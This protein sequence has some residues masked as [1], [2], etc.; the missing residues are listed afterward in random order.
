MASSVIQST[1]LWLLAAD[2]FTEFGFSRQQL[3]KFHKGLTKGKK[4]KKRY[5]LPALQRKPLR[6]RPSLEGLR[7]CRVD[8]ELILAYRKNRPVPKLTDADGITRLP[9]REAS[10]Q[11]SF[12]P[13]QLYAMSREGRTCPLLRDSN[14]QEVRLDRHKE[15][16]CHE[17]TDGKIG[18][19]LPYTH[20]W[21]EDQ[22]KEMERGVRAG[23]VQS[24]P[25]GFGMTPKELIAK[26]FDVTESWLEDYGPAPWYETRVIKRKNKVRQIVNVRVYSSE[27]VKQKLA[28]PCK[29][30]PPLPAD[31]ISDADAMRRWGHIFLKKK[32]CAS[33]RAANCLDNWRKQDIVHWIGRKLD[34]QRFPGPNGPG[35]KWGT[36]ILK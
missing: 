6:V 31:R 30:W 9:T 33:W 29:P 18:Q 20:Y 14:F 5:F 19:G 23:K 12:W 3:H 25:L 13:R 8:L 4:N 15:I 2:V 28:G 35:Y 22:L 17:G 7:Y 34:S 24:S 26:G 16:V 11:Y 10:R 36:L 27:Q 1:Q 21:R 32:D